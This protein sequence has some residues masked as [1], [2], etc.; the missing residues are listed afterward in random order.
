MQ[1]QQ[2]IGN[3]AFRRLLQRQSENHV[4]VQRKPLPGSI[5]QIR[6][7]L[8]EGRPLDGRSKTRM[9]TVF[10]RHLSSVRIHTDSQAANLSQGLN[11]R[12]FS[13]GRDIAFGHGEYRP[14][15][16]VGDALLAHEL[17]HTQQ[18]AQATSSPD[19]QPAAGEYR[20]LEADADWS[21]VGA[22]AGLWHQVGDFFRGIRVKARPL[23][24][25]GLRLQRCDFFDE[26]EVTQVEPPA[27]TIEETEAEEPTAPDPEE[28][29]QTFLQGVL[30]DN[31]VTPAEWTTTGQRARELGIDGVELQLDD[32]AE[33]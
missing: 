21:A 20:R 23:M 7:R 22:V 29:M 5:A 12:A 10:G 30:S 6:S 4:V 1:L 19:A 15:T 32:V 17:A 14:G 27:E 11:A 18:Q 28:V 2:T 31:R 33:M 13:I 25:S 26:P 9:E 16:L 24:K 3:R 8:G